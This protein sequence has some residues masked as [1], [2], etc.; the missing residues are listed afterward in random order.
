MCQYMP[1]SVIPHMV[2]LSLSAQ[3]SRSACPS[4]RRGDVK[5]FW[6]FFGFGHGSGI[7][8]CCQIYCCSHIQIRNPIQGRECEVSKTKAAVAFILRFPCLV[9]T[10]QHA[11]YKPSEKL[12]RQIIAC[13]LLSISKI[14]PNPTRSPSFR[15]LWLPPPLTPAMSLILDHSEVAK[16]NAA[17]RFLPP[18]TLLVCKSFSFAI[19]SLRCR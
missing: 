14:L 12:C 17:E 11:T 6:H 15:L 13:R 16:T 10:S 8:E 19:C 2:A 7:S 9:T 3:S 4:C 5:G 18:L 1:A